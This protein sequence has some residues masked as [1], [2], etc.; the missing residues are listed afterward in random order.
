MRFAEILDATFS[1]YR[2]HFLL[3]LGIIS[4]DFCGRLVAYSIWRFLPGFLLKDVV[5]DLI[6]MSFRLVSMGGIIIAVATI[7]L[8]GRITSRDAL[9][10][11]GHRFWQLLACSLVWSLV[12]VM[13]RAVDLFPIFYYAGY[14]ESVKEYS[15]SIREYGESLQLMLELSI[16]IRLVSLPFSIDLPMNWESITYGLI[17]WVTNRGPIWIRF[18]PSIL[19]PFSIYFA[20]RWIFATTAVLFE[21]PLIRSAFERSSELTRG[22]WWWVWGRLVSFCV[23]SAAITLIVVGMIGFILILTTGTGEPMPTDILKWTV[24]YD[25]IDSSNPLFYVIMVWFI[26]IGTLVFPIWVIGITLLYFDLRI[27]KEGFNIEIQ[28]D[29]R[30]TYRLDP[31]PP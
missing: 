10:Q 22:R 9:K 23:L 12:F 18:I 3:F 17:P 1:L 7:Y 28:V 4:L 13:P 26:I 25:I 20:V 8:S 2:K 31:S 21:K 16:F 29:D 30:N 27:R 19:A 5:I 15:G 6:S 14:A 24:I 11:A